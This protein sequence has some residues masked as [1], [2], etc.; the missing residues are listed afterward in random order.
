[1]TRPPKST[2]W[3]A[4]TLWRVTRLVMDFG[5]RHGATPSRG[6]LCVVNRAGKAFEVRLRP[7]AIRRA[8]AQLLGER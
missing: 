6:L 2:E 8:W 4:T 3:H 1:M 7:P 5:W